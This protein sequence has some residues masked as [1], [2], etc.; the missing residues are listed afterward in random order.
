MSTVLI[1]LACLASTCSTHELQ[2]ESCSAGGMAAVAAWAGDHP[3]WR[4]V[5]WRC[6]RG[7]GA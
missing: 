3:G 1:V 2:V 5:R 4:V 7:Q 6:E